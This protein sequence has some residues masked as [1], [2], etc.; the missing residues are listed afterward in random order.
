VVAALLVVS[1]SA[2]G[3]RPVRLAMISAQMEMAVS[4]GVRPPM[5]SPIGAW[6]RASC[7]SVTPASRS[8]CV[9]FSCVRRD[10]IAPRYPTRVASEPTIAGTSNFVSWVSTH[11]A[12]RGP[13]SSPIFSR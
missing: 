5:S 7:S 11:T 9:R 12:S 2:F 1:R 8:R 3:M 6:M 10:P 13:S 4:S